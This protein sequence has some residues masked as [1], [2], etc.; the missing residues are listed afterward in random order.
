MVPSAPR[1]ES[2]SGQDESTTP[3][4]ASDHA[5]IIHIWHLDTLDDLAAAAEN[6]TPGADR[7][8]TCPD[9]FPPEIRQ[10]IADR[11]PGAHLVPVRN[12]GQDIGALFQLM[13]QVDL[14]RYAFIC[15]IHSK[16]GT[17]MP[18]EWRRALLNG[19]LASPRQVAHIVHG[20]R[21]DPE[22][23]LAGARQLFLHGPANLWR[24][25]VQIENLFGGLIGDFDFQTRDWGFIGGTCFWIRTAALLRLQAGRVGFEPTAYT[26]DETPAHAVER[27]FGM[28]V[29]LSGGKVLLQDLRFPDRLPQPESGF[30]GDLPRT[31]VSITGLLSDLADSP[32]LKASHSMPGRKRVAVFASYSADG[33]LPPQVLPYLAGLKP[34]TS[35]I[36][37]VCDNDLAAG[38]RE[39]LAPFATHVI[40]GRHGEYDFGSYKRGTAWARE[41]G[42]L[43]D[44]DDLILCNDSCFG[45][46]GS[47]A[48]MCEA[49]ETRDLDF[50]GATDSQEF[51][52]HLQSYWV[53][54]SRKVFTSQAFTSF[55]DGVKK[56]ENVQQVI[57]KYEIGLTKKL[58]EAGFRADAFLKNN[59]EATHPK[60]TTFNN[61][62]LFPIYTMERGLPLVKVKALHSTKDN[63]EGQNR[64]LACL[65]K[66]A[67]NIYDIATSDIIIKKFEDAD[68]VAFSLIMPT[69]NRAHCIKDAIASILAQTHRNFELIIVDDGSSDGTEKLIQHE[70][71][72]D[73]KAGRI[74]YICLSENVGVCNARNIGVS[75]AK[76]S[77]ISYIDSDNT[78]RPYFLTTFAN[79]AIENG[80]A[81]SLY[82]KMIRLGSGNI[83]GIPYDGER[84]RVANFID[85]GVFVH[86]R[87]LVAR[88]GGFDSDMKRLVDWDLCIRYTQHKT[89]G[90]ISKIV[91]D[92]ADDEEDQS[93]IS[94]R[95]SFLKAQ[96]T[97]FTKHRKSFTVS[98]VIVSYN[99]QDFIVEA[100]ESALAQ[101]GT[102]GREI[103]LAD[104]GSTDGTLRII[105][106]YAEKYPH[107]IRNISRGGNYG[108]SENYRHCFR[109]AAGEFIAILEGD[110]YW[111]D[112]EKNLKQAEFLT[113]NK[114]AVMALSRIELF[115]MRDNSHRLLKRQNNL[116]PLLTGA[117]FAANQHLNLIVN[118]SSTMFRKSV[119]EN[120]PSV[121]YEPRISEITLAFYFDRL[122]KIGFLD[123][124]MSIYRLNPSSVWTGA[125]QK[126]QLEQAIAIRE[127]AMRVARPQYRDAIRAQ[128]ERKQQELQKLLES[129][130]VTKAA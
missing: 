12:L 41:N 56:E 43:D 8:V 26:D 16:K 19:V 6:F 126:S 64:T 15:K 4:G 125:N 118:L 108:I 48:P 30:P 79:A 112:P 50:W 24:N 82:A 102:F 37:V 65:R 106:R 124:V 104:D 61:I 85:L 111:T 98:T 76:N 71:P 91:M 28:Q 113:R 70:Y 3:P 29:A 120:L 53:V 67:P 54:L 10:H 86:K 14:G 89:P 73:L 74:R 23:Q 52:Y 51:S 17:K 7:F 22:L 32:Y 68:A 36:I 123:E 84:I 47:F 55:I 35:A 115:N 83:V 110:D 33:Y 5:L 94:V 63:N 59:L 46:V 1:A 58:L 21:T 116:K 105:E 31:R 66:T 96:T 127:N 90:F 128:L 87:S 20:F 107:S 100:I 40:T 80:N 72:E 13:E 99:H 77:W 2:Q 103:L 92:Y 129:E 62:S 34:L 44:A 119:M 117:D 93:R 45:P 109:E 122:G 27:M 69:Y 78:L 49:M 9:S 25:T 11:L 75:H 39:K 38:E 57:L 88:F 97:I 95:E 60:D 114:E 42:L 18:N 81:D 101:K 121:V 130:G